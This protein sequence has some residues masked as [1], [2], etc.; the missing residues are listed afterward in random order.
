V[1]Q[2]DAGDL[3][4]VCRNGSATPG[5]DGRSLRVAGGA[6]SHHVQIVSGTAGASQDAVTGGVSRGAVQGGGL[7]T[8]VSLNSCATLGAIC[9]GRGCACLGLGG[10]EG[11]VGDAKDEE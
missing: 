8:A 11:S 3:G 4:A 1:A 2:G 9:D 5:D 6:I 10:P 7:C